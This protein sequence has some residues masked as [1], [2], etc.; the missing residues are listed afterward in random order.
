MGTYSALLDFGIVFN[1]KV[2]CP[3]GRKDVGDDGLSVAYPA[4]LGSDE[5][6]YTYTII[7]TSSNSQLRFL[8]D[9]M[10]VI[11]EPGSEAMATWLDPKRTTWTKEL[12]SLLKPYEGELECYP[13]SKDVG[14]VG[15]NS[16][17]FIV[18]LDSKE[19]K[20]NIANFF[21]QKSQS[22]PKKTAELKKA[23]DDAS[24]TE[25]ESREIK[26]ETEGAKSTGSAGVKRE[27]STEAEKEQP[28]VSA[29]A[30]KMEQFLS[31]NKPAA[32]RQMRSATRNNSA[33]AKASNK[34]KPAQG[35]PRI[36]SF[37]GK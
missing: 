34:K 21:G 18:P 31:P 29:K 1:T 19:N 32:G 27:R 12:Q 9:R 11:L 13:V 26:R 30:P 37:F 33:S 20:K 28:S 2:S 17:N 4:T 36:T 6:L 24:Q 15:N 8:H 23:A 3:F 25:A 5:K 7:T 35:T 14:K 10:P 22:S 16:P